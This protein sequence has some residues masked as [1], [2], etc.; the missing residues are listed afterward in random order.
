[1]MDYGRASDIWRLIGSTALAE[2]RLDL[3]RAAIEYSNIRV[4]WRLALPEQRSAM[5]RARTAAHNLFIDAC[6]VL[7]RN[8][9]KNGESIEWRATLGTDR[10]EIGDFACFIVLFLGLAAR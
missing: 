9:A 4:Q 6:N 3:E 8:M 1:M 2:L 7:S 10:K 5:D